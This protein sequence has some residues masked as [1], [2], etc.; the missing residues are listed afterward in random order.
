VFFLYLHDRIVPSMTYIQS[1]NL[2]QFRNYVNVTSISDLNRGFIVLIGDNGAGK[3]NCLEA[4]SL[5][6]PGRGLRGAPVME[7]QSRQATQTPW[8]ISSIIID[9][10]G[11][12]I[13]IGVG[14]NP[15]KPEKKTYRHNG[16]P[17]KNQEELARILRCV[18]LTP[19]MDGLFLEGS[20]ERRRFFDRLVSTF[21]PAHTGRMTR[22]EKANRERLVLLKDAANRNIKPDTQWLNALEQI[23]SESAVAIAAS[24]LDVLAQ[25][26]HVVAV[27]KI[28]GFP[29]SLMTLNGDIENALS[30]KSALAVEDH[31]RIQLAKFRETDAMTGRSNYGIHRTDW[32]V[33]HRDKNIPAAQTSTGEQKA[34]L[35]GIILAH[36]RLITSRFGAPPLLLFD[37]VTAHFDDIRR[38]TLFNILHAM[39]G[40]I[41]LTGQRPSLFSSLI[42]AQFVSVKENTLQKL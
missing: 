11:D 18:W 2:H 13:Q 21:D 4:I 14:R 38:D 10:D 40:Q 27:D 34:L 30:H 5:L 23:M 9:N 20:T 6:S 8:A 41:W 31:C 7:C 39:N 32:I 1:L 42:S 29:D 33:I 17:V 15:Q 36:A 3:T 22:Y 37:E 28:T 12:D 25:L 16:N 35:T 19:Q 24:R 26:Q